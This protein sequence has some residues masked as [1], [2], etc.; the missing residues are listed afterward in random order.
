MLQYISSPQVIGDV[1]SAG[2]H[3]LEE[4]RASHQRFLERLHSSV[5]TVVHRPLLC[6]LY[7]DYV[8]YINQ[9]PVFVAT[10]NHWNN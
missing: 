7:V 8:T 6:S 1:M 2:K 3:A 9:L 10:W 4:R 5:I